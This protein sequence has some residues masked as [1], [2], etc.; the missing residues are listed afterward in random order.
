MAV[1]EPTER[2]L[3]VMPWWLVPVGLLLAAALGWLVLDLLL[4]EADRA[5]QPDTRATLRIDAIRTG[6]P[7][8]PLDD[9]WLLLVDP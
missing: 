2:S 9:E 4:T 3:R 1:D 5:S 7:G 8:R 6:S